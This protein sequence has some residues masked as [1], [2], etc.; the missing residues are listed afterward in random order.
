MNDDIIATTKLALGA[1]NNPRFF[2]TERGYAGIFYYFLVSGLLNRNRLSLDGDAI[3]EMEYQ[4]DQERHRVRQ[5]PDVIF[6]IPAELSQRPV[7]ENNFA[8]WAFKLWGGS[9]DAE[10]DFE[11]L[12]F[13]LGDLNYQLGFFINISAGEDYLANYRGRHREKLYGAAVNLEGRQPKW[14]LRNCRDVQG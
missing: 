1:V 4:K 13:M 5:R 9:R 12:D 14:V 2:T 8:V 6:H 10:D 7:A 11:K 3:V